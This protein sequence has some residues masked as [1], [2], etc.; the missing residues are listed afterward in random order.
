M[1]KEFL[2]KLKYDEHGL[3]SAIIQD[4]EN[5]EVLMFAFANREAL[6]RTLATGKMHFY[7]RSR[8]KLWLKGED[9]GHVQE[10]VEIRHDCDADALLARVRQHG[11]ACHLGF[12]SCFAFLLKD[13]AIVEDGKKMFDP[14]QVYKKK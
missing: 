5:G 10:V 3:V 6:E 4:A 14:K 2:D 11:G 12:R 1:S 7:S 8:K 13:G 9:S